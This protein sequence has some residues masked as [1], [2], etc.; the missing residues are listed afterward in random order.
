MC[1]FAFPQN[2]GQ[3]HQL[4]SMSMSS[5]IKPA[6]GGLVVSNSLLTNTDT[7]TQEQITERCIVL[8]K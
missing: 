7:Q 6:V 5:N 1:I 2:N 3:D 4:D 8:G